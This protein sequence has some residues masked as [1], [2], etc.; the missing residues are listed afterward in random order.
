MHATGYND[1]FRKTRRRPG[2]HRAGSSDDAKLYLQHPLLEIRV[3]EPDL[4][5]LTDLPGGLDHNEWIALHS[6]L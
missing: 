4:I 6:E 2:D 1:P 3:P 5:F